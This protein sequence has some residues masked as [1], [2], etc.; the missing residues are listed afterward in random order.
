MDQDQPTASVLRPRRRWIWTL[1]LALVIFVSGVLVGSGL[2]F[3][4]I[5]SGFKKYFQSPAVSAERITHR[6]KKQLDLTDEQAVQV[7][8][9]IFEQQK[10][11][12]SLR[13]QVRPQLDAQIEKTRQELA[14]VLTPEQARKWEKRFNR[15]LKFWLPPKN[16]DV[17]PES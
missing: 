2:T 9:I 5:T 15:F 7:H 6:M 4:V 10:A 17:L 1:L 11:F 16:G 8:R 12:Q 13:K 3:K 14:A